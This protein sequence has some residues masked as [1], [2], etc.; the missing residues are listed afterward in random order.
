MKHTFSLAIV[1]ALALVGCG[2][3][4]RAVGPWIDAGP[5][6]DG[7][8]PFRDSGLDAGEIP[9]SGTDAGGPPRGRVRFASL[10]RALGPVDVYEP[11]SPIALARGVA[12]RGAS[13]YAPLEA[14][15]RELLLR[16]TGDAP[17]A[18]PIATVALT[19]DEG[20]ERLVALGGTADALVTWIVDDV[21]VEPPLG[22]ASATVIHAMDGLGV[23]AVVHDDDVGAI[24]EARQ[25]PGERLRSAARRDEDHGVRSR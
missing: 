5:R 24:S 12:Y 7:G 22:F 1:L 10:S 4:V 19:I 17:T 9:D 13:G 18:E 23:A 3:D 15:E 20:S 11:D 6:V 21:E 25:A 2:D 8:Y 16:R 14:G